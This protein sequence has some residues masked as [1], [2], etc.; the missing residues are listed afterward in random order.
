MSHSGLVVV[1]VPIQ[2]GALEG[3]DVRAVWRVSTTL[4][5]EADTAEALRA[6][7]RMVVKECIVAV[8]GGKLVT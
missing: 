6:A 2:A 1:E 4:S 7:T 3:H 8:E 5:G